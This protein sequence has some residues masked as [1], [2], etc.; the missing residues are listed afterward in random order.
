[1][2]SL[3]AAHTAEHQESKDNND[4]EKSDL[5]AEERLEWLVFLWHCLQV[6]EIDVPNIAKNTNSHEV[7]QF[8]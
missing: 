7:I 1:M 6:I 5:V 3:H 2:S 4:F 8:E